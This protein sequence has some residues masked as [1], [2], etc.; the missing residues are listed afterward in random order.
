MMEERKSQRVFTAPDD[1]VDVLYTELS[2]LKRR[3]E[4]A[5]AEL[6]HIGDLKN[7][8]VKWTADDVVELLGRL[9]D[10][11]DNCPQDKLKACLAKLLDRIELK[12]E[13]VPRGNGTTQRLVGGIIH[14]AE[15]QVIR[16]AGTRSDR[17]RKTPALSDVVGRHILLLAA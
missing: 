13:T 15:S 6:A 8:P 14:L 12:F 5:E 16:M 1:M 17:F 11:L 7:R 4:A 10:D 9:A 3:R 2:D